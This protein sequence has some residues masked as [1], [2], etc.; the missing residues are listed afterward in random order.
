MNEL[1]VVRKTRKIYNHENQRMKE[2]NKKTYL[3]NIAY[4]ID[5][6]DEEYK[7]FDGELTPILENETTIRR[8]LKLHWESSSSV[9]LDPEAM[10]CGR[11][12][13]CNSWVTDRDK[14]NHI[15]ELNNGA[16]VEGQLLCDECL[17][18]EHRWAF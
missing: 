6:T 17:S 1:D 7:E 8:D 2:M 3:V 11:C 5:L 16:V 15:D 9:L 10:N 12:A 18:E 13:K 14:P 4:L